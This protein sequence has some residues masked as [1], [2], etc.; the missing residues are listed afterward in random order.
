MH[1]GRKTNYFER[2]FL[3]FNKLYENALNLNFALSKPTKL[4]V[5]F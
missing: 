3:S 2:L 4:F 1:L 5:L